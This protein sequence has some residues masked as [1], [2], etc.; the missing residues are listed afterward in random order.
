MRR[1]CILA[2]LLLAMAG[3]R[4]PF[5]VV[6]SN[7]ICSTVP[8][9]LRSATIPVAVSLDDTPVRVETGTF[10]IKDDSPLTEMFIGLSG[11]EAPGAQAKL[12]LV[13]VDGLLLNKNA[14]GVMSAGE[15]PVALF[16][17]KLDAI[18]SDRNYQGVVLRIN[19]PGGGVTASDIMRRD[20]IDFKTRTG[21]PVVAC[22]MDVGAGGA[23]YIATAADQIVAHPTSL[24]GGIGVILNL[25]DLEDTLGVAS[26]VGVP[27]KAG[28]NT[29]LGS[30][31]RRI[32][33]ESRELLQEIADGFHD[34]FRNSVLQSRRQVDSGDESLFDGRVLPAERALAVG[35][36]DRIAYLDDALNLGRE[37]AASPGAAVVL[38]H[39]KKD[40]ARTPYDVTP[41]TPLQKSLFPHISGVERNHLPT[42]MYIW[43]PD[44]AIETSLGG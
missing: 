18:A 30:P 7:K 15:N 33:P 38:L 21:L 28:D 35:L 27:I 32:S 20:L 17:E 13:D 39:R 2:L 10:P 43:Q 36:V 4:R 23:Y 1:A 29:D 12:A 8:V 16:R 24:V 44:P 42:F 22:L 37:L 31:I 34:R 26:I 6:T 19:S 41:N 9:S 25:Y 40:Q 5:Q 14:T 11:A 3:C